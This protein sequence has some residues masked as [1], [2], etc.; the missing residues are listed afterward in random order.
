MKLVDI[1]RLTNEELIRLT[2]E[3]AADMRRKTCDLVTSLAEIDRRKRCCKE[4][5]PGLSA[6][7]NVKP[8]ILEL[9]FRDCSRYFLERPFAPAAPNDTMPNR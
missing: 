3:L 9:G 7:K 6:R 4:K 8:D 2:E 1:L 5:R